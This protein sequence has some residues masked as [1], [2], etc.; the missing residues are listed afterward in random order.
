MT[1]LDALAGSAALP[2]APF[3]LL[4]AYEEGAKAQTERS[5]ER[6]E[7]PGLWRGIAF[8]VGSQWLISNIAEVKEILPPPPVTPVPGTKSWFLGVS[9]VRGKLAAIIDLKQL[10]EGERTTVND[11]SRVL[12]A[13]QSD[14]FVGLLIDEVAG[15]RNLTDESEVF[16][17]PYADKRYAPFVKAL[18]QGEDRSWGVFSMTALTAAAEFRQAA[19]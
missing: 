12:L 6:S 13:R 15:Q 3:D 1:D 16:D 17:A 2:E 5:A 18:Y 9:N 11:R 8:R 10:L 7:A 4:L 19:L 14:G